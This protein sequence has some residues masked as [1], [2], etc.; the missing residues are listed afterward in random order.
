MTEATH[1][2]SRNM[3]C[4]QFEFTRLPREDEPTAKADNFFEDGI[5]GTDKKADT[6][7]DHG[8]AHDLAKRVPLNHMSEFMRKNGK[9]DSLVIRKCDQIVK[10]HHI[11]ARQRECIRPDQWRLAEMQ[12]RVGEFRWCQLAHPVELIDQSLALRRREARFLKHRHVKL[13]QDKA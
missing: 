7:R 9:N 4:L 11:I 2:V 6:H 10:Q 8:T 12:S 13:G 5:L 1:P 3:V